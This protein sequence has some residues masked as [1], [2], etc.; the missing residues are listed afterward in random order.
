MPPRLE[1]SA[2]NAPPQAKCPTL[3]KKVLNLPARGTD[4]SGRPSSGAG[5][6]LGQTLGVCSDVT[7]AAG[8]SGRTWMSANGWPILV[9]AQAWDP[10]GRREGE[11]GAG[12]QRAEPP[13]TCASWLSRA[14]AQHSVY[15]R[16]E[17]GLPLLVRLHDGVR[18][19]GCGGGL[20]WAVAS[21]DK[22]CN[23][24]PAGCTRARLTAM[25]REMCGQKL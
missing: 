11:H 18:S 13:R 2:R 8:A 22:A 21:L 19:H 24:G 14:T 20:P 1:K 4:V 12:R 3:G 15:S 6:H 7:Q 16:I 9:V 10:S 25:G 5:G 17:L 23:C